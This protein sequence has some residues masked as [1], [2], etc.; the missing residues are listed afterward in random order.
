MLKPQMPNIPGAGVVT[1]T[2]DFVKNLWGSMGVPGVNLAAVATPT[3]SVEELDKKIADLKAV[4]AWL[5]VNMSMVRGT[6]QALEV[7]RG[8]IATLKSMGAALASAVKQPGADEKS[9]LEEA[10]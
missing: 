8:T 3:L 7:Q 5:N 2:L 9:V 6:V 10:P 1:D 4:E